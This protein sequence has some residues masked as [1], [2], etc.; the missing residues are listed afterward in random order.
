M[1]D[2]TV[3]VLVDTM[4][5]I[6]NGKIDLFKEGEKVKNCCKIS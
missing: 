4:V 2:T 5:S 1:I 3:P 6:A